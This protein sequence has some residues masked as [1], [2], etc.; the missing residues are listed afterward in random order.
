MTCLRNKS[1]PSPTDH[2]GARNH[3]AH[4]L[5]RVCSSNADLRDTSPT[6]F[7]SCHAPGMSV[8]SYLQRLRQYT[9]VDTYTFCIAATYIERLCQMDLA[10]CPTQ[11]NVHRLLLTTLHV[12]S[13][14]ADVATSSTAPCCTASMQLR[15]R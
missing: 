8:T 7:D 10:F 12:A 4:S 2:F 9:K 1:K 6:V 15:S 5:S 13:K 11:L 3:L 14:A